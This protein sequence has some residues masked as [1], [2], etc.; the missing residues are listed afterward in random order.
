MLKKL[1]AIIFFTFFLTATTFSY[2]AMLDDIVKGISGGSKAETDEATVSSGL[3]EALT[4]GTENAV[5][6]ISKMDGYFGNE[7]IKI[8]MPKK[9]QNVADVL[10]KVGFKKQ[11]D[12]FILSMNRAAEK[13]APK[14][15][16]FFVDAIKQ[17]SFEDAGNILKG[18]D[19]AATDYFKEKTS[20]NIYDAF[21]P[22]ISS[23][24]DEVGVT[25]AYKEMMSKY[26][27][28]PLVKKET[29]DLDHYVTNKAL[30]GLF[31]MVGQEEKKIRTDPAARVTDLLK[32]VF[33]K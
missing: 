5:K 15:T 7:S 32:S 13:A 26:E 33:G 22:E 1:S 16:G 30:E 29:L 11:V 23:A 6:H 3:K 20:K 12:D 8:L 14:A 9:I 4:V 24:M 18:G 17:M 25:H 28:I 2:A 10:S 27:S 21:K 19:T 31:Y